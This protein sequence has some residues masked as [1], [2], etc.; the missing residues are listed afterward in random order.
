M[1]KKLIV[2]PALRRRVSWVIA[3]VLILPFIFFFHA[4]SQQPSAGAAGEI[5]GKP[6]SWDLFQEH[7]RMTA[8]RLESQLGEVPEA[9]RPLL[10]QSTWDWLL[11]LEEAKRR[12]VRVSDEEVRRQIQEEPIFRE[13]GRFNSIR[14]RELLARNGT[15]PQLFESRIR[16]QLVVETLIEQVR[17]AVAVTEE[18]VKAAYAASREQVKAQ[19]VVSVST[20]SC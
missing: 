4:S 10:I 18:D 1:F 6:V 19:V 12:K 9:L 15:S 5:F 3:A 8:L 2:S 11:L 20:T 16:Q 13:N 7:Y 14:Y 17:N